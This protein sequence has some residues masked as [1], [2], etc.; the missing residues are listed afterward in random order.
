V[1][2]EMKISII[3]PTYQGGNTIRDLFNGINETL[4]GKHD[5]EVIFVFDNGT[6]LTWQTIKQLRTENPQNIKAF[7]LERNYGQHRALKYG[8]E[9]ASGDLIVTIDEDLQHDPADILVLLQKQIEGNYDI[10]YGRFAELHNNGIRKKISVLLRKALKKF[11][12]QLYDYY[13]PYRLIKKDIVAK[14]I[15]MFSPYVFIDDFLCRITKNISFVDINHHPRTSGKSSYTLAKLI[16]HGILILLA[17]SRLVLILISIA[18]IFI[19]TGILLYILTYLR[20]GNWPHAAFIEKY[21]LLINIIGLVFLGFG[22][23][24]EFINRR[25]LNKNESPVLIKNESSI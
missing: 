11:I 20:M 17:Y 14:T 23:I 19:G 10:V 25:N 21:E 2:P 24:G 8:F 15:K 12:P 13:S 4:S 7:H 18:G 16:K 1:N 3:V 6:E 22:L 9:M 5:F